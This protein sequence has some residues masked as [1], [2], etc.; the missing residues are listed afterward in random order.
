MKNSRLVLLVLLLAPQGKIGLK[1]LNAADTPKS[2]AELWA[3]FDPRKDPLETEVVREW[4]SEGMVLRD[5][6][7]LVGA[8]K[9]KPARMAAFYGFPEGAREKLPAIM[10]MHGGGGRADL[11]E[12]KAMVARGYAALSVN[13]GGREMEDSRPGDANT[14]WGA[15]DPTQQ[16]AARYSSM[17]PGPKQFYEDREHP[18][19]CNWYLLTL[20]CR[21]GLTFLEQQPE[22]DPQ[23]LG[24]H[25]WSMGGNLTMYVAGCD[26]RV[27]AAVPGVGGQGW[28]W[29]PHLFNGGI[30]QQE[31]IQGD[32]DVFRRTL[33]F[34]SY[35]PRIHCPLLHRSATNDHHGLMDDVYRTDALIEGQPVRHAWAPH[36]EHRITPE[37][38]VTML[39]WFD[40]FLKGGPALP[41]TPASELVL[42]TAEGIPV[43]RVTPRAAWPVARCDIYYSIDPDPLARFWRSAEATRNGDVFTANLP[44]ETAAAPLFAFANVYYTLPTPESLALPQFRNKPIR[45]V[46]LSSMLHGAT[47]VEL[48][49]A[50]VRIAGAASPLIDDFTHGWRDWYR[51][52]ED[53]RDHWQNWTRKITDPKWRGPRGAKLA[54]TFE[55]AQTNRVGFV[56]TENEWRTYRGKRRILVCEKEI[57]GASGP[58]TILLDVAEF[59]DVT[60]GSPLK[61]WSELDQLGVGAR[62]QELVPHGLFKSQPKQPAVPAP[63]RGPAPEFIRLEW[64]S[65]LLEPNPVTTNHE[66]A[67]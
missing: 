41:E 51:L 14:D 28:R 1:A 47:P 7:F 3:D 21:R 62:L 19:N 54:I 34:E 46:C 45:E 29:Q 12:V 36:C 60:D 4:K 58:Q 2:V 27:K 37:V 6:R 24:I 52:N 8:L 55:M 15:V 25:G 5:V 67:K 16:N 9:G 11:R 48:K 20:G 43:M 49:A 26:S 59:K 17:L 50:G 63:W 66:V 40:H 39:L 22:V 44:L 42:K 65:S 53:N 31:H 30:W 32:L 56:V 64:R 13:W 10:H 18:K 38:A 23:R 61:S 35:A 33:S 57:P